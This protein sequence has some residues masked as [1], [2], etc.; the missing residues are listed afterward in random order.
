MAL[1]PTEK[2]LEITLDYLANDPQFNKAYA[3]VQSEEFPR[4]HNIVQYLQ[5]YEDVSNFISMSINQQSDRENICAGS[6]GV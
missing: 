4:I 6:T 5:Q 3:Y 1:V 2:V